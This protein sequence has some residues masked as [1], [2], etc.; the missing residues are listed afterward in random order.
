MI[1]PEDSLASMR[2]W[3][4]KRVGVCIE[5]WNEFGNTIV[6]HMDLRG[7]VNGFVPD[8]DNVPIAMID[9]EWPKDYMGVAW[10]R[11]DRLGELI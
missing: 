10:K 9:V 8:T 6:P 3:L 7:T 2:Y 4:G 5:R 11:V 1:T